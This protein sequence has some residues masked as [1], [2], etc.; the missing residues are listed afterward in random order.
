MWNHEWINI[1]LFSPFFRRMGIKMFKESGRRRWL[2]SE[3]FSYQAYTDKRITRV[4]KGGTFSPKIFWQLFERLHIGQR[5]IQGV[6][7]EILQKGCSAKTL[8][9]W[10]YIGVAK[11]CLR[12]NGS[13]FQFHL[14]WLHFL[15][16][17][18]ILAL[19]TFE[20]PKRISRITDIQDIFQSIRLS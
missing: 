20:F 6:P 12:G 7:S 3:L 15:A 18:R 17:K 4:R 8:H 16:L 13:L 19:S 9:F 10:P 11:M 1:D 2:F 5:C 14:M